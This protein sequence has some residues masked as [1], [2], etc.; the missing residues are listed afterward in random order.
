[1][2]WQADYRGFLDLFTAVGYAFRQFYPAKNGFCLDFEY[3]KDLNQG[4]VVKQVRELPQ[5]GTTNSVTAFLI[6]EPVT[7]S[8]LQAECG[9]VFA[10]HRLKS[11]WNLHTTNLW[12]TATNLVQ[13]HLHPGHLRVPRQRHHPDADRPAQWLAQRVQLAFGRHELLDHG[14]RRQ[15][16]LLAAGDHPQDH[17]HRHAAADLHPG[18]LRQESRRHLRDGHAHHQ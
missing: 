9:S 3:K 15:S 6:D 14:H 2:D 7:Y 10:S 8:V 11:L 16:P 1:M 4:L 5:A 17:G 12:L 18:R 13:R